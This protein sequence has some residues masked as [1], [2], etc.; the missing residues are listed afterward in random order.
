MRRITQLLASPAGRIARYGFSLLLL[1]L[2]VSQID[3][4]EFS[5]LQ[6]RISLPLTAISFL[7]VGLTFP[8]HAWRWWL[9]LR[10][11]HVPL[12]FHWAHVVTWIGQFYNAFLLG[13]IGGDAAR[14]FYLVRDAS[15][16]RA[17]ALATLV[18]D[19]AIGLIVLTT[20]ATVALAARTAAF[21]SDPG[22]RW[23]FFSSISVTLL[24]TA[25]GI[26]LLWVQ[27]AHWPAALRRALGPARLATVTGLLASVRAAPTVHAVAVLAGFAM[28]LMDFIATWLLAQA[29]GLPLPFLETCVAL[30]VAY[31]A[32]VLPISVGG[33]GVREGALIAT[34][35]SF[36]LLA[37]NID[38]DRALVLALLV[39]ATN[40]LWSL[41]GGFFVL[42]A[43]RLIPP[44][45]N[46]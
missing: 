3:F 30:S 4:R 20:L 29:V 14:V 9:L 25:A 18:L 24:G 26:F 12:T 21:A 13:G 2:L 31:A 36:G 40:V 34:L 35:A 43:R 15:G 32:T 11:Q 27:P 1:A 41:A 44:S 39:W 8:L 46:T 6:G 42:F 23:L 37:S 17:G 7:L 19:R 5:T 16:Q 38:H 28:W 45:A 22:L 10:T 33:H